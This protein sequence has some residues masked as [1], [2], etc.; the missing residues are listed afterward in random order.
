MNIKNNIF[1]ENTEQEPKPL[2]S[3]NFLHSSEKDYFAGIRLIIWDLDDTFWKGTLSEGEISVIEYNIMLIRELNK[4]GILNAI[5]SKNNFDDVKQKLELLGIWDEFVFPR[6]SWSEKGPQIADIIENSQLRP[7]TVLF[8]DD[9]PT[10]LNEAQ[11]FVPKINI[12]PPAILQNLLNNPRFKGKPDPDCNR[13]KQYRILEQKQADLRLHESS[14]EA[15]LRNSDIRISFHSDI[16]ENFSRI[17]D[18]VNRTNQLN[19]TKLRWPEDIEEARSVYRHEIREDF[20]IDVGYIKVSD[21]YGNYGICGFYLSLHSVFKHFLFSCRCMNMGIEQFV[22]SFLNKK[23]VHI[24]GSVASN[25]SS[26]SVDWVTVVE[27]ADAP[28]SKKKRKEHLTICLRG[29][30]DL[31]QTANFMKR[32][33]TIKE[34]FNY[35]YNK[36]EI[37]TTPRIIHLHE[38]LKKK[39]NQGIIEQMTSMIPQN[40]F[41]SSI[42]REDSDVYVLSFSQE[43]FHGLYKPKTTGMIIPMGSHQLPYFHPAGPDRK[44]DLTGIPYSEIRR[45]E[46]DAVTE[47]EWSFFRNEFEFLGGFNEDLFLKDVDYVFRRLLRAKKLVIVLGLNDRTGRNAPIMQFFGHIN[48]LVRKK[49]TEFDINFLEVSPF[50][51]SENKL[52]NDGQ[53]VGTHFN[54]LVYKEISDYLLENIRALWRSHKKQSGR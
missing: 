34:E 36:W 52:A 38:D 17:H 49:C 28:I 37:I 18:L 46:L 23:E 48:T 8:V 32:T 40:R 29:A 2:P 25:L 31:M 35:A 12:A 53:L 42:L 6:I 5:C 9:N 1:V 3:V 7:E 14:N 4:R 51:D 16:E 27:D 41:D 21:K 47:K 33:E 15:F 43:S 11:Y 50:I 54:R 30:C 10:N 26:P 22:W 44:F 45:R 24:A 39:K 20:G 19:F 13:L